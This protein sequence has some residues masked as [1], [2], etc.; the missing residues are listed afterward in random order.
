MNQWKLPLHS[1]LKKKNIPKKQGHTKVTYLKK[2][3]GSMG[4]TCSAV[5]RNCV[6][7]HGSS[8]DGSGNCIIF[9]LEKC[10]ILFNI[11]SHNVLFILFSVYITKCLLYAWLSSTFYRELRNIICSACSEGTPNIMEKIMKIIEILNVFTWLSI[12]RKKKFR[13]IWFVS[14]RYIYFSVS[15]CSTS[16]DQSIMVED[17]VGNCDHIPF[18]K[19]SLNM[20]WN[21][22]PFLASTY[23]TT[24]KIFSVMIQTLDFLCSALRQYTVE[25]IIKTLYSSLLN[26]SSCLRPNIPS[27]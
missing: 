21:Y 11:Y 19:P 3:T 1:A 20:I 14:A 26:Y 12:E 2:S 15:N 6:C 9:S 13:E 17:P 16:L 4:S 10:F 23:I 27:H 24:S 25:P 22:A 5:S 8:D 18:L 7:H